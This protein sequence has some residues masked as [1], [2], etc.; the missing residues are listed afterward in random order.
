M[1]GVFRS[2]YCCS[3]SILP[4]RLLN[5]Q[6]C[7][8]SLSRPRLPSSAP[9]LCRAPRRTLERSCCVNWVSY[10]F[11]TNGIAT[12][13]PHIPSDVRKLFCQTQERCRLYLSNRW[14]VVLLAATYS[15]LQ[16][17]FSRCCPCWLRYNMTH[18]LVFIP[19]RQKLC[20]LVQL[21]LFQLIANVR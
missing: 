18:L 4:S 5:F 6:M 19:F 2:I 9:C 17:R 3:P 13:R 7:L 8:Q 15:F 20:C 16:S 12:A 21:T 14:C 11:V 10:P 1:W